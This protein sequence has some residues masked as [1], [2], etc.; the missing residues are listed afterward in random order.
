VFCEPRLGNSIP[1]VDFLSK[2][3]LAPFDEYGFGEMWGKDDSLDLCEETSE[4]SLRWSF[5]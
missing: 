2:D 1:L 4:G 3:S 5:E